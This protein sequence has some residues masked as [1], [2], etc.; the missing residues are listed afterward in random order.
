MNM[1]DQKPIL[2]MWVVYEHPAD[3]PDKYVVRRWT[4]MSNAPPLAS[5]DRSLHDTLDEAREAMPRG[6]YNLKRLVGDD[7]A[8]KEV[9]I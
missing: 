8:I 2:D 9:W 7:P 3:F 6:L 5:A 4:I 1:F